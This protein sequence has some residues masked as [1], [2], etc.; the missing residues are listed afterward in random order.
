MSR[1]KANQ[2][3]LGWHECTRRTAYV[4]LCV[5]LDASML[6]RMCPK[7]AYEYDGRETSQ[8]QRNSFR[9]RICIVAWTLQRTADFAAELAIPT[10]RLL[11]ESTGRISKDP[12]PH[13]HRLSPVHGRC[14]I[15]YVT[16]YSN[17]MLYFHPTYELP[18]AP[19]R[20]L[21]PCM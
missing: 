8:D 12:T 7:I 21:Q 15:R 17:N 4:T 10:P 13:D 20:F 11:N 2:D 3:G 5:A 18:V 9:H 14:L 6:V 16:P 1:D 19:T